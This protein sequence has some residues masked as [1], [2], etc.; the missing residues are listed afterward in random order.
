MNDALRALSRDELEELLVI[1]AKNLV[2]LDGTWFQSL[3][4][5]EGMDAAMRHDVEAW[6]RFSKVEARRIKAFLGSGRASGAR[7]ASLARCPCAASRQPTPTSSASTKTARSSTAS[8]TAAC[9]TR[10]S[11]RAWDSTRARRVGERGASASSRAASTS[12]SDANA[13]AASPKRRT[14]RATARGASRWTH[15]NGRALWDAAA[16]MLGGP[17]RT[18]TCNQGIMSPLLRH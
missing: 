10:A 14:R 11:A 5:S 12:A 1:Y 8:P 6:R 7:R 16:G 9:R 13:S 4:R 3:E 17:S 18:R 15:E 2:A